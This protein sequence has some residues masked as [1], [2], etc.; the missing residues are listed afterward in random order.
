VAKKWYNF[1]V[2]SDRPSPADSNGEPTRVADSVLEAETVNF[3]DTVP[4]SAPIEAIY[5]AAQIQSPPHG[6]TILKIAEMLGSEHIRE[7]PA[8]VRRKSVLVALDAAGVRIEEIVE[9]AVRR[10]RALDTY[11]RILEQNLESLRQATAQE[12]ARL[13]AET[14]QRLSELRGRIEANN[15]A[16]AQGRE[17][18][19]RWRA[20]KRTEESRIA[21]AVGYFVSENPITRADQ[22]Q[23]AGDDVR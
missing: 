13:E 5:A 23:G 14:E 4:E 3:S 19:A 17:Q 7:L 12:N 11:E 16:V 18:L 20:G 22:A 10:D 6:Y 8:E 21:E 15:Q 1:F 2:V 9:D